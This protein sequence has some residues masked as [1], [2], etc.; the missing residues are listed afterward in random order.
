M[1]GLQCAHPFTVKHPHLGN[2]PLYTS[3]L[4]APSALFC[5]LVALNTKTTVNRFGF[6]LWHT[7]PSFTWAHTWPESIP[8][9]SF[10]PPRLAQTRRVLTPTTS[11]TQNTHTHQLPNATIPIM[12][13]ITLQPR[14]QGRLWR[15][16]H[17]DKRAAGFVPIVIQNRS[18]LKWRPRW[19]NVFH[20]SHKFKLKLRLPWGLAGAIRY[21][22]RNTLNETK[23][24]SRENNLQQRRPLIK[25]LPVSEDISPSFIISSSF[26]QEFQ[27]KPSSA[28]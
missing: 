4:L 8:T 13:T 15:E 18:R 24:K 19:L 25:R 11:K 6:V 12:L 1:N 2:W 21:K 10:F 20:F 3:T 26:K 7:K 23:F 14:Q 16:P 22:A 17:V 9:Q 27:I 28:T 5:S